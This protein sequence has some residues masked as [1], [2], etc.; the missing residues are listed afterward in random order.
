MRADVSPKET[1]NPYIIND[2]NDINDKDNQFGVWMIAQKSFR[3]KKSGG[4]RTKSNSSYGA[5]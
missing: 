1:T 2:N 3:R 5:S 4:P